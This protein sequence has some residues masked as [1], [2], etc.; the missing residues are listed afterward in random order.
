MK[1]TVDLY[2][3]LSWKYQACILCI[4]HF[5]WDQFYCDG[6][7]LLEDIR[8]TNFWRMLKTFI[9]STLHHEDIRIQHVIT[10]PLACNC[11]IVNACFESERSLLIF[12]CTCAYWAVKFLCY[13]ICFIGLP[14]YMRSIEDR[15]KSLNGTN[16]I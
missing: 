9:Y 10:I 1:V 15:R 6:Y 12:T 5:H 13:C 7:E 11:L 3:S 2:R 8:T 14:D 16:V 4:E